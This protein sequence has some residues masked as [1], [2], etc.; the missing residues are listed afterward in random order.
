MIKFIGKL[1]IKYDLPKDTYMKDG[2]TQLT[3]HTFYAP[4][5]GIM[6]IIKDTES[7]SRLLRIS[8]SRFI[9]LVN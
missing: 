1:I 9:K 6:Y 8:S 5:N 4:P 2:R 3:I 7:Y